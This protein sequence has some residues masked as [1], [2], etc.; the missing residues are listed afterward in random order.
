MFLGCTYGHRKHFWNDSRNH[1]QS[2]NLSPG[3]PFFKSKCDSFQ[4]NLNFY[5]LHPPKVLIY[6]VTGS[7]Y[8]QESVLLLYFSY[9]SYDRYHISC[10]IHDR[11]DAFINYLPHLSFPIHIS[12][13]IYTYL[14]VIISIC[15][16]KLYNYI[17]GRFCQHQVFLVAAYSRKHVSVDRTAE[18]IASATDKRGDISRQGTWLFDKSG[19]IVSSNRYSPF[20]V[21]AHVHE[22]FHVIKILF[23][24][25]RLHQQDCNY[26]FHHDLFHSYQTHTVTFKGRNLIAS[27]TVLFRAWYKIDGNGYVALDISCGKL[28][29]E[30]C[31]FFSTTSS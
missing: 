16:R 8:K 13:Y 24:A 4:L 29:C 22:L 28:L 9:Y 2:L 23:A 18:L 1:H 12:L 21:Y 10:N 19:L 31:W 30:P 26:L 7:I 20:A 27:R 3:L 25:C 5:Y 17:G 15:L 11:K 6:H 14:A